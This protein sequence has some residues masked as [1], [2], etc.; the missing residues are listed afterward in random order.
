M[1][2]N[3]YKVYVEENIRL[4]RSICVKSQQIIEATNQYLL[5]LEIDMDLFPMEKYK[6]YY[7]LQGKYWYASELSPS[8]TELSLCDDTMMYFTP[9]ENELL[10]LEF[11]TDNLALYPN[12]RK[13][14]RD[15]S[16]Y[17]RNMVEKYPTQEFLIRRIIDPIDLPLNEIIAAKDGTILYYDSRLIEENEISLM[18]SLQVWLYSYVSRWANYDFQKS[19]YLYAAAWIGVLN[20]QMIS[21]LI[22]LRMENIKTSEV[23]S[24]HLWTYLAGY[25]NLDI[26]RNALTKQQALFL[27]RNIDYIVQNAGSKETLLFIYQNMIK[28][29]GMKLNTYEIRQD[30]GHF[31]AT[32]QNNIVVN[33]YP[34]DATN[35]VEYAGDIISVEDF[36]EKI[37]DTAVLNKENMKADIAT[38]MERM[39]HTNSPNIATGVIECERTRN[40]LDGFIDIYGERYS[41]WFLYALNDRY[42]YQFEIDITEENRLTIT[43]KQAV[44]LLFFCMQRFREYNAHYSKSDPFH[45]DGFTNV[46]LGD[47]IPN[48]SV[49]DKLKTYSGTWNDII[50]DGLTEITH[51]PELLF[52]EL[53]SN[54]ISTVA[55]Y[56]TTITSLEE[57]DDNIETIINEKMKHIL[58]TNNNIDIYGKKEVWERIRNIYYNPYTSF[59]PISV[60][61]YDTWT[62]FKE[63]IGYDLDRLILSDY[64]RLVNRITKEFVGVIEVNEGIIS[65][66]YEMMEILRKL[67]SYLVTYIPSDASG[68]TKPIQWTDSK[69]KL[70]TFDMSFIHT[71]PS[72]ISTFYLKDDPITPV[73]ESEISYPQI[74]V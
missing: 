3:E 54:M 40:V 30:S 11:T 59:T 20:M 56:S 45:N 67:S 43:A 10:S 48:I 6:Y 32:Y 74:V 15:F 9:V 50:N 17:Y 42:D 51:F 58:L 4:A 62:L 73:K 61:G 33:K 53:Q 21:K 70:I 52:N 1:L 71:V 60:L 65:P 13:E 68:L 47:T 16:D 7:N 22:N 27:Y 19:D 63:E 24:F 28:N 25:F 2:S 29:N 72:A 55:L 57:F 64:L 14:F 35:L 31:T 8:F 46:P 12:S 34:I 66:Y 38:L 41:L 18:S 49:I 44:Y 37:K 26:Y 69:I 36:I 39:M 23:H 5:N